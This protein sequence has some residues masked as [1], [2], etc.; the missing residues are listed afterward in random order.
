[1]SGTHESNDRGNTTA[2]IATQASK[3]PD[4]FGVVEQAGID[5]L[6]ENTRSSNPKNLFAVFVGGN[7]AF[8]VIIFGWLPITFGLNFWQAISSSAVGLVIGLLLTAPM[9]LLAPRTGTN[10]PVSSGAHFGVRGR[11][12]GSALTLAFAVAYAAIAVWTSGEA[13]V[14]G[15]HRLFGTSE[16]DTAFIIGYGIIAIVRIEVPGLLEWFDPH[17]DRPRTAGQVP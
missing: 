1:M 13:L 3:E 2:L 5:Y 9:T 16:S 14:A 6:P 4:R 17:S 12:I 11:L 8:S 15:A 10:N 7:M